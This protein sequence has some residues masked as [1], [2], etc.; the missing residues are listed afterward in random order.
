MTLKNVTLKNVTL[1]NGIMKTFDNVFDYVTLV[2]TALFGLGGIML[3]VHI[4]LEV[5]FN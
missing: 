5:Y 1:T 3:Q 4:P 2:I